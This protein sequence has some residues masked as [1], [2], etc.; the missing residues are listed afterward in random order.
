MAI[1]A[2]NIIASD[3]EHNHPYYNPPL[4]ID[5]VETI[6]DHADWLT[7]RVWIPGGRLELRRT[8][9]N[10]GWFVIGPSMA[11]GPFKT[12]KEAAQSRHGR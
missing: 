6:P 11:V 10:P 2:R 9:P 5:T 1:D 4:Q 8:S 12:P 3:K 7:Q